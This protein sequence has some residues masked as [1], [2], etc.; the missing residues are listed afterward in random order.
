M[1]EKRSSELS[2]AI[3]KVAKFAM[4]LTAGEFWTSAAQNLGLHSFL[5]SL[6]CFLLA[7]GAGCS[8]L[9]IGNGEA[10]RALLSLGLH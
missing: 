6:D 9:Q 4:L 10:E 7:V 1:R 3:H 8:F 2:S 5:S